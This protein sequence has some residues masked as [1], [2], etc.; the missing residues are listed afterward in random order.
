MNG[1]LSTINTV[2]NNTNGC[3]NCIL[4]FSKY[5]YIA[6]LMPNQSFYTKLLLTSLLCLMVSF[7]LNAQTSINELVKLGDSFVGKDPVKLDSIADELVRLCVSENDDYNLSIAYNFDGVASAMQGDLGPSLQSFQES[8]KLAVKINDTN[9]Q[10]NA[11]TNM[12]GVYRFAGQPTKAVAKLDKAI[13]LLMRPNQQLTKANTMLAQGIILEELEDYLG[14]RDK[15]MKALTVFDK[16]GDM[17]SYLSCVEKLGSLLTRIGK[18][19][20][21]SALYSFALE[22][23]EQH[24]QIGMTIPLLRSKGVI[25]YKRN[26]FKEAQIHLEN[27]LSLSDS[28]NYK[29]L[30]DSTLAMLIRVSS[31]TGAFENVNRYTNRLISYHQYQENKRESETLASLETEYE[32]NE[33]RLE[34]RVLAAE[35]EKAQLQ[36]QNDRNTMIALFAIIGLLIVIAIIA[37]V[38]IRRTQRFNAQLEIKVAEKTQEVLLRDEQ[39]KRTAFKLAHELRAGVATL[40]GAKNLLDENGI[41]DEIDPELYEAIGESTEKLDVTIKEMIRNLEKFSIKRDENAED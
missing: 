7:N 36:L 19:E 25:E 26:N 37:F 23:R 34:N 40:L 5:P 15:Y 9:L 17:S 13:E 33:Q 20:E 21:A 35:K 6:R 18:L 12:A 22:G 41:P 32:L 11:L 39:I 31:K 1:V 38:L 2:V 14:A 3:V 29:L 16:S 28:L 8:W 24:D 30:L 10:V 4:N 27:A